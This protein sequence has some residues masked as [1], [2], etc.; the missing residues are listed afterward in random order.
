VETSKEYWG[1][2]SPHGFF[3]PRH[4]YEEQHFLT[5]P[6]GG[7]IPAHERIYALQK[8][9]A[10]K[11][12]PCCK[13]FR[14]EAEIYNFDN[15]LVLVFSN[16]REFITDC[17]IHPAGRPNN[18]FEPD[19]GNRVY[20]ITVY[21]EF[22]PEKKI[23]KVS[24]FNAGDAAADDHRAAEESLGRQK[25]RLSI[26]ESVYVAYS[27]RRSFMCDDPRA[28]PRCTTSCRDG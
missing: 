26:A 15:K 17:F 3:G 7:T 18:E 25:G 6:A 8:D 13:Y 24:A 5:N 12:I 27:K 28:V 9:G 19:P 4:G 11:N 10:Y 16:A 23:F 2:N 22:D 14:E 20:G 21:A 1:F